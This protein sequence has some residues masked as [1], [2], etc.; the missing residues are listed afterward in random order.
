[1]T[2][3]QCNKENKEHELTQMH[4]N[5]QVNSVIVSCEFEL[6]HANNC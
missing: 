3:I 1:M 6:T 2:Q 5:S 4:F